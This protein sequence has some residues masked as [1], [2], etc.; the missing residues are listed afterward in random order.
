MGAHTRQRQGMFQEFFHSEVS[1][2]IVLLTCT[3]AALLWANSPWSDKY[4]ELA[5]TYVGVGWGEHVF[6]LSLSHWIGDGLMVIFFLVVGL[7]IKRELVVGQLST[8]KQAILPVSAAVGGM[9]VPAAIFLVFNAGGSAEHGWGIPMATDIAFALGVLSLFGK[10]VPLGLKVFL[11][12]LAIVDDMGA[13]LVIAFFYTEQIVLG[14]L[15]VAGVALLFV[16]LAARFGIRRSGV[17]VVLAV[18]VWAGVLTSGIH[19]TIAGVLLAL[20]IP[21]KARIDPSEFRE[22][23]RHAYLELE[24][25]E[26]TRESMVT[27]KNQMRLLDDLY[28]TVEDMRPAGIVIEHHF[29]PIQTFLILPLFA[30]FK[31]G[32]PIDAEAMRSLAGPLGLG[33]V[34]GLFLGKQIGITLFSWIAIRSGHASMP[35]GVGWGQLWG[36]SALGGIGFTM[37]IFVSELAFT[38]ALVIGEAKIAILIASLTAGVVGLVILS[39][40]LPKPHGD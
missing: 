33:V 21:V 40:V 34:G 38:D 30:F 28:L 16:F 25:T 12:A 17:Y 36:A 23:A 8:A 26:L 2:S 14:G 19:A 31:A 11:T 6:K 7:E 5:H 20:L 24:K 10:R 13:V 15:L 32:V 3:I 9:L 29:H 37:S 18:I 27:D 35:E 22:R 4:F 39:R 1:G